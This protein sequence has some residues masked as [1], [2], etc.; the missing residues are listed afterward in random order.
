MGRQRFSKT[1]WVTKWNNN[2]SVLSTGFIFLYVI[3]QGSSRPTPPPNPHKKKKENSTG[4]RHCYWL[5]F[6]VRRKTIL[7]KTQHILVA[8]HITIKL[9][10]IW[11]LPPCW[12]AFTVL[13]CAMKAAGGEKTSVLLSWQ[14]ALHAAVLTCQAKYTHWWDSNMRLW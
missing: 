9:G 8:G 2:N 3:G 13:E 4:Y 11:K 7:L 1:S 14:P 10:L 6:K 5:P 12:L